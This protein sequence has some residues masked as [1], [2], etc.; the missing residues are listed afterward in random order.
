MNTPAAFPVMLFLAPLSIPPE[1]TQNQLSHIAYAVLCGIVATGC[2]IFCIRRTIRTKQSQ[3]HEPLNSIYKS[4]CEMLEHKQPYEQ[5]H[6][7][8]LQ[9]KAHIE[10]ILNLTNCA[11]SP[12]APSPTTPPQKHVSKA[13]QELMQRLDASIDADL[14]NSNLSI[15]ELAAGLNLSR[16]TLYRRIK[17]ITG[18]SPNEYIRF[19]RV[20][21]AAKMIEEDRYTLSEISDLAGFGTQSYFSSTFKKYLGTTPS[22]YKANHAND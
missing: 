14:T 13:D 3:L 7:Q 21:K 16:S 6:K 20:Q 8:L 11:P 12:Q 9:I 18:D 15:N 5:T 4:L 19:Y 22:E 1:N 10:T 2:A 17:T